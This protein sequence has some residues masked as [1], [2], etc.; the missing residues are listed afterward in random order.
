M[1][2]RMLFLSIAGVLLVGS[3]LLVGCGTASAWGP[4]GS[5]GGFGGMMGGSGMMGGYGPG[6][7]MGGSSGNISGNQAAPISLDQS[8]QAV[9]AYVDR[10]GNKDLIVDEV[11]EF[12]NNFYA[13]VKEKSSGF[14]AFEL[15]VDRYS[16]NAFPEFGP[17]MMWNTK[18]GMMA[19][20][21][22]GNRGNLSISGP[23]SLMPVTAE[24]ARTEAQTWLNQYQPGSTTEDPD[25][26]YGYY[27]V[28]TLKD[29]KIT[30]MLSVN[31][32]TGQVWYHAWHGAFIGVKDVADG[33]QGEQ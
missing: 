15:L 26:F 33:S 5:G 25:Q 3:L 20:G 24:K 21:M 13:V 14:G 8:V 29:G 23:S 19:G 18:Y 10:I 4:T 30:G 32:Y 6:G 11:M 16:G 22:M 1:N 31:G 9:Q 27:T 28:H 7:M 2:K 17:G 12:Q